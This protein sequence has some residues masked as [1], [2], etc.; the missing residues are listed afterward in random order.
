MN[1]KQRK[2]R[3]AAGKCRLITES[4]DPSVAMK[5]R[6]RQVSS[7]NRTEINQQQK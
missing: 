1:G 6:T 7:K 2:T 4:Q 3:N 5:S